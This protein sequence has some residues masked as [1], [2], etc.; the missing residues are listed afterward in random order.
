[1]E[2][3]NPLIEPWT[4]A[5]CMGYAISALE[6]LGYKHEDIRQ[7]TAEMQE[8]FDWVSVDEA[9]DYYNGSSY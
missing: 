5:A 2:S 7:V 3:K 6:N 4:N 1:M 8:L 9:A